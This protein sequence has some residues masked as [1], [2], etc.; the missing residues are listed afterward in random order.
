ML[1]VSKAN[2]IRGWTPFIPKVFN[3]VIIIYYSRGAQWQ[4]VAHSESDWKEFRRELLDWVEEHRGKQDDDAT[5][6]VISILNKTQDYKDVTED[7]FPYMSPAGNFVS[8]DHLE[9]LLTNSNDDI[10]TEDI[11]GNRVEI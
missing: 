2:I 5:F 1:D 7:L 8:K 9:R 10:V 3:D 6:N 11:D 4:S